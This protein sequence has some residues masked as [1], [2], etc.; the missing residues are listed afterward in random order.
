M[1]NAIHRPLPLL[2]MCG[3]PDSRPSG[4]LC[5]QLPTLA[6]AADHGQ[7][8]VPSLC[9]WRESMRPDR[10]TDCRACTMRFNLRAWF[11]CGS[12]AGKLPS[13]SGR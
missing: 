3:L 12:D 8:T 6:S 4:E 5:H 11:S 1:L 10:L 13:T 7:L 9:R 2:V